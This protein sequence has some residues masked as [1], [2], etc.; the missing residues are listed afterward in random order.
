MGAVQ[1]QDYGGAKWGVGQR[2]TRATEASLD[3]AFDAGAILRTHVLRPTWHF[4]APSDIRWMLALT[5]PRIHAAMAYYDRLCEIDRPTLRRSF[6]A[7]EEALRDGRTLTRRELQEALQR[8]G[9]AAAGQRLAHLVMN[10]ELDALICSGPRRG[11]QLTYALLEQRVPPTR[12]LSPEEA[13]AEL[14]RRYLRSH[15]PATAKDFAWWSGFTVRDATAGFAMLGTAAARETVSGLT[16]WFLTSGRWRFRSAPSAHL[17]PNYDE[18]LIAYKDRGAAVP[19]ELS[20]QRDAF[21]H[22]LVIDG[23]LAGSWKRT[24]QG[25]GVVV[26]VAPYRRITADERRRVRA[27]AMALGRF[28]GRAVE[29][30]GVP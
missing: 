18:Y 30:R 29:L 21:A 23:R 17:L 19:A 4:V 22:H 20:G 7:L 1:A 14:S 9:V 8:R 12:R 3:R 24:T 25:A 10:A 15:G 11:K 2:C 28:L 27:A 26:N 16:Y 5:A 6:A 13:L